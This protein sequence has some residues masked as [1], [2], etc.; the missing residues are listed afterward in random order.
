VADWPLEGDL[1]MSKRFVIAA[2]AAAAVFAAGGLRPVP[3]QPGPAPASATPAQTVPAATTTAATTPAPGDPFAQDLLSRLNSADPAVRDAAK[4]ELATIADLWQQPEIL[5]QMNSITSDK[6]IQELIEQRLNDLKAKQAQWD[7]THL[8]PISLTV[9]GANLTDLVTALNDALNPTVKLTA[10]RTT[11]GNWT[12]D[13]KDKPFW[14]VF[15]LLSQQRPLSFGGGAGQLT[16][17]PSGY[18]IRQYATDGPAI[19][20]VSSVNYSRTI[21]L[22]TAAGER[23]SPASLS[24]MITVAVDPRL[25]VN[26]FQ[27]PSLVAATDDAGHSLVRPGSGGGG[28]ST[29]SNQLSTSF[30]LQPPDNLG[31]TMSLTCE[32]RLVVQATERSTTIS[33][34]Q[35][36]LNKPIAV[37][38]RTIRVSRFEETGSS[39][40]FQFNATLDQPRIGP[41]GDANASITYVVIDGS[42]RTVWSGSSPSSIGGGIGLGAATSG[43]YKLE[44]HVPDK[45]IEVPVHLELKDVPL[46]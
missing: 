43:P 10:P 36:N 19:A 20:Y 2:V 1:F 4:K 15:A 11:I 27:S 32:T 30:S 13:V 22:Q 18:A 37:G 28:Y 33:D 26:R 44:I 3:A 14:E 41:T 29:G 12:L 6:D 42:G 39:I 16:L 8:P 35:S 31:K 34:I 23:P 5:R 38:G 24:V 21:A 9:N 46:P 25:R 7:L 40:Q 45:T 17:M